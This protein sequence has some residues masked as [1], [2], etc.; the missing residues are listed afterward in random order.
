MGSQ[1]FGHDWVPF[2]SDHQNGTLWESSCW[3]IFPGAL[4]SMSLSLQWATAILH[5]LRRSPKTQGGLA[6]FPR[7]RCF[8]L[9]PIAWETLRVPSKSGVSI[10]ASP[11]ECLHSNPTSLQSWRVHPL[12]PAL[13]LG[14]DS[15][16]SLLWENLYGIVI[17]RFVGHPPGRERTW[18]SR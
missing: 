16:L 14:W 17:F 18:L 6:Q 11:P 3:W 9:S 4:P 1:T 13:Q 10:S 7:S 8:A 12:M 2:T 15:E 5:L